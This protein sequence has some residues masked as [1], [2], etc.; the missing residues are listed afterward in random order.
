MED[1]HFY[2]T[3]PR[4]KDDSPLYATI[5]RKKALTPD[6]VDSAEDGNPTVPNPKPT[7]CVDISEEPV[8]ES[9]PPLVE[10]PNDEPPKK[11]EPPPSFLRTG[12]V[13][14]LVNAFTTGDVNRECEEDREQENKKDEEVKRKAHAYRNPLYQDENKILAYSNPG[15]ENDN[16]ESGEKAEEKPVDDLGDA[17]NTDEHLYLTPVDEAPKKTGALSKPT[18]APPPAPPIPKKRTSTVKKAEPP[19]VA[20]KRVSLK[21]NQ[22]T[23]LDRSLSTQQPPVTERPP[24]PPPRV[25]SMKR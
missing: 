6:G 4:N 17:Q 12:S 11:K 25:P 13:A 19:P 14:K 1:P 21:N 2:N 3:I 8:E 15:F 10:V 9:L 16:K 18:R 20:P 7:D 22:K 24:A 23:L 5:P